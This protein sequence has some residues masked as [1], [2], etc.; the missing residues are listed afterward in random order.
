MH[1]FTEPGQLHFSTA[2]AGDFQ[3]VLTRSCIHSI[4]YMVE[5]NPFVFP[6]YLNNCGLGTVFSSILF[7]QCK[8]LQ[9]NIPFSRNT[10]ATRTERNVFYR[11]VQV[12]S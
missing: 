5:E 6:F 12:N 8:W 7:Q 1:H 9:S 3:D 4:Y 10:F 11:T 2:D